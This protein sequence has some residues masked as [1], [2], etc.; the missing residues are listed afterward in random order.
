[1]IERK[2]VLAV[3]PARGG[4]KRLPRKNCMLLHGKPLI[5][6]S[7]EAAQQSFY[8]DEVVVS[9]DDEEIASIARQAGAS[10]PFLRPADLS[11]DETSSVDVVVHALNYYQ[12]SEKKSF[13][14]VVLLQ[15][16]SPLRA[17]THIDQAFELLKEKKADAIVSVCETE[18]SPLWANQLPPDGSMVNFLSEDVLGRRS[19]DLPKYY[20]LNGAIYICSRQ[21]FLQ[22]R[23][24]LVASDVYAYIMEQEVSVDIDTKLD[25]FLSETILIHNNQK[26]AGGHN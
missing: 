15:P 11:A 10:V 23:T 6:Y 13:D 9:T 3:I 14:Y 18:H 5:V 8:I 17:A 1:M 19:Q 26:L 2:T 21:R 24:F 7:I 20:R 16:T 4:S 25:L 22:E 12:A